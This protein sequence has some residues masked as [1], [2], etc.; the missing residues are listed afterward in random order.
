MLNKIT[1]FSGDN[2]WLSNF[3]PSTVIYDGIA[4]PTVENAYQAA[5]TLDIEARKLIQYS[6]PSEAKKLGK[7]VSIRED[8]EQIKI[9]VM[10]KLLH[11]KF[12]QKDLREKLIATG[13]LE[14][15]EGNWWGDRF[16]GVCKGEGQNH[17]GKLLMA[18]RTELRKS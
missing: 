16:W 15:I 14:L 3:W 18:I 9:D 10:R 12:L 2:R 8:W 4:Y 6:T 7:T 11:Q 13:D 1:S 17:L 5:K